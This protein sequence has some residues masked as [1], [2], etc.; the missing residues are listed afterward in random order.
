[1][2]LVVLF[3]V[4]GLVVIVCE[5]LHLLPATSAVL[6][7]GLQGLMKSE[8]RPFFQAAARKRRDT[9]L[10]IITNQ[11]E[12]LLL[13]IFGE[14]NSLFEQETFAL[15][16][17][18]DVVALVLL[19]SFGLAPGFMMETFSFGSGVNNRLFLHVATRIA[20]NLHRSYR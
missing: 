9:V 14:L 16:L 1:M 5:H 2:L 3:G 6:S 13:A 11:D 20:F 7:K 4:Q 8:V 17:H 15:A 18:V 10:K 19:R 12:Y